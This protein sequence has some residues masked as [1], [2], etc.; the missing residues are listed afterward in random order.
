M[1]KE[2]EAMDR[3]GIFWTTVW[4]TVST[5]IIS[6]AVIIAVFNHYDG[7][8]YSEMWNNCVNAG[9][10]PTRQPMI[11]SESTTFTCVRN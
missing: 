8:R 2:N 7:M 3:D 1:S 11:G 9:G 5:V 10:Q 6:L 4:K